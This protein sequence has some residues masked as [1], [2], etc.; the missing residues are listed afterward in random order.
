LLSTLAGIGMDDSFWAI[1][2]KAL[3]SAERWDENGKK[4]LKSTVKGLLENENNKVHAEAINVWSKIYKEAD[5]KLY[6]ENLAYISYAVNTSALNAL[7]TA[8][9]QSAVTYA[10]SEINSENR[11]WAYQC[12]D[13]VVTYGTVANIKAANSTY[14][15]KVVRERLLFVI[16][17]SQ[18]IE[19]GGDEGKKMVD[20]LID[21]MLHDENTAV[22]YYAQKLLEERILTMEESAKMASAESKKSL[23]EMVDYSREK[24]ATIQAN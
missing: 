19:R 16:A 10:L 21:D 15:T 6:K 23:K 4:K 20:L 18:N 22:K 1:K 14:K 17:L 11:N 8:D 2:L 13:V 24:L 9:T 3:K 7:A 5:V 12:A